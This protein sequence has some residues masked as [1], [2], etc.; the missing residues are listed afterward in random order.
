M[1]NNK[2]FNIF[3][4]NSKK[5]SIINRKNGIFKIYDN[6]FL[7]AGNIPFPNHLKINTRD[8]FI[9]NLAKVLKDLHDN[10]N[11]E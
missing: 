2:N 4:D 3:L 9:F 7:N 8:Q 5:E 6:L 10:K 1:L 11:N